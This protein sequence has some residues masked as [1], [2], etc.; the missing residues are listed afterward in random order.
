MRHMV[1]KFSFVFSPVLLCL[2]LI[3][4]VMCTFSL[5]LYICLYVCVYT[6]IGYYLHPFCG[7]AALMLFA[8]TNFLCTF[9]YHFLGARTP[10]YQLNS[11]SF[12]I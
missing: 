11:N 1:L 6:S 8:C 7:W 5:S 10:M 4:H 3:V 12:R 9:I 2:L